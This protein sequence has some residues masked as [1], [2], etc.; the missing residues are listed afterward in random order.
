MTYLRPRPCSHGGRQPHDSTPLFAGPSVIPPLFLHSLRPSLNSF[1]PETNMQEVKC[2]FWWKHFLRRELQILLE[3]NTQPAVT[4]YCWVLVFLPSIFSGST[5][6]LLLLQSSHR[7]WLR[8][9]RAAP[10]GHNSNTLHDVHLLT[11]RFSWSIKYSPLNQWNWI[12]AGLLKILFVLFF[13]LKK[14]EQKLY[15]V[16]SFF[17][18]FTVDFRGLLKSC[19]CKFTPC[20]AWNMVKDV[21]AWGYFRL[22]LWLYAGSQYFDAILLSELEYSRNL[23]SCDYTTQWRSYFPQLPI[24]NRSKQEKSLTVKMSEKQKMFLNNSKRRQKSDKF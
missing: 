19:K 10:S 17:I 11:S 24:C 16:R 15:V 6:S 1:L 14:L 9:Q 8:G 4:E 12:K 5:Y 22:G 7:Q 18:H 20:S 2:R 3:Q 23:F 21:F 13:P